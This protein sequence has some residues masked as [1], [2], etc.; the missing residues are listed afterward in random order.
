M[1]SKLSV[2]ERQ[3]SRGRN[4]NDDALETLAKDSYNILA[5]LPN[6]ISDTRQEVE[7][8]SLESQVCN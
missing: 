5:L 4:S 2:M 8:I 7:K 6:F 1:N 3:M